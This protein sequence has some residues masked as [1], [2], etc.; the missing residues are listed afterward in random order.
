MINFFLFSKISPKRLAVISSQ[1]EAS[2]RLKPQILQQIARRA[3][4]KGHLND[5]SHPIRSYAAL[6]RLARGYSVGKQEVR[7]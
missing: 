3:G 7:E 6:L 5:Y 2:C 1:E 4:K